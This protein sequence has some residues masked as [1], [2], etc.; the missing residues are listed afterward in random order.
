LGFPLAGKLAAEQT[1]EGKF[2]TNRGLIY[3]IEIPGTTS[4]STSCH[5]EE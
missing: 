2:Y 5:L 4:S 1:D 3:L